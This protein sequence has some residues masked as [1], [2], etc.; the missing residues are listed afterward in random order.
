MSTVTHLQNLSIFYLPLIF[1]MIFNYLE[2]RYRKY[3]VALFVVLV[4]QFYASWY[5]MVFVLVAV[6]TFLVGAWIVK[7]VKFRPLAIIAFITLLAA[8]ATLPL[9]KEYVRFSKANKASFGIVDQTTYSSSLS[10][11]FSPYQG[12]IAGQL[13]RSKLGK[14]L[15]QLGSYNPDSASYHGFIL[16]AVALSLLVTAF[17]RRKRS[18]EQEQQNKLIIIFMAIAIIGFIMSLGPLLKIQGHYLY[19]HKTDGMAFALPLPYILVSK[20]LPQLSFIRAIGRASVLT[21]F[22]LCCILAFVPRFI[23]ANEWR[24]R[25]KI[26]AYVFITVMI[27]VEL[28]PTHRV[29]MAKTPYSYNLSIPA[30]YK[31]VRSNKDVNNLIVLSSDQDYP[32][33]P[34]P[35]ARAENVL[36]SGYYNRNIFNGYSGYTPPTYFQDYNDFVDFH[37]D[38][39]AKLKAG[40]IRY[41]IVD[42][43]LSTKD[44]GLNARVAENTSHKLYEDQRYALYKI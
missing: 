37:A 43:Q 10:D 15:P 20:L 41:I 1:L 25:Y 18:K 16:Y 30:V 12:T 34:I 11:Y 8:L 35:V 2:A 40:D 22:S 32:N 17:L 19:A 24:K 23:R 26:T 5:Q 4:L 14:K 38:D 3:L 27:V 9:A 28:M 39:I 6:F 7:Y 36:W 44:P 29:L 21:L 42:K 31:Y 33:A 13:Y